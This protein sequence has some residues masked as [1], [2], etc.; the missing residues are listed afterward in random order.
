MTSNLSLSAKTR[1][2]YSGKLLKLNADKEPSEAQ[3]SQYE[4]ELESTGWKEKCLGR[5]FASRLKGD[6]KKDLQ[7][8]E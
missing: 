6:G 1:V 8:N 3:I 2:N 5:G 7:S 4:E